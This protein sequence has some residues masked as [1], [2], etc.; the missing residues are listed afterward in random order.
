MTKACFRHLFRVDVVLALSLLFLIDLSL[1]I[2]RLF[3]TCGVLI[4]SGLSV[5]LASRIP[6][7]A[8][9]DT[10]KDFTSTPTRAKKSRRCFT[11][12]D[13]LRDHPDGAI[14]HQLLYPVNEQAVGGHHY[15]RRFEYGLEL[16]RLYKI[17]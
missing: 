3:R 12:L 16:P 15:L 4:F 7:E 9:P 17:Q 1:T 2:Q 11:T 5:T 13:A 14:S 6:V 10:P 8:Q